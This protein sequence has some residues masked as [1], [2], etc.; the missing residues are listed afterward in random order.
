[1]C[2]AQLTNKELGRMWKKAVVAYFEILSWHSI[3]GTERKLRETS[4]R[5]G[6]VPAVI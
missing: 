5:I 4:A 6:G 3:G 2:I 1:M